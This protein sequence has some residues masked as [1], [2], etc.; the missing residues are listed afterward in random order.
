MRKRAKT[1]GEY[2]M[3][4]KKERR[5][6][7]CAPEGAET[8]YLVAGQELRDPGKT[9]IRAFIFDI[10]GTL[11]D[12]FEAY[13]KAF[14]Q[15]LADLKMGRLDRKILRSY[16]AE[17]LSLRDILQKVLSSPMDDISYGM[18]RQKIM[19]RFREVE[20]GGVKPFPGVKELFEQLTARGFKI[21]VATGR[22]SSPTDEWERFK[23][24]GLDKYID[25]IVTSAEVV[26]R[27]PAPDA[28]TECAKRLNVPVGQCCVIGDTELDIVAAKSAGAVAVAVTTGQD[29]EE[30]LLKAE[31]VI[32]CR[33]LQD[34]LT[35]LA[36][37]P[38]TGE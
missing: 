13:Y 36:M 1:K 37:P 22:T 34:L 29:D 33:N 7:A 35:Q 32:V 4:E 26:H 24:L 20:Q 10:D 23:K 6:K 21:G 12:S 3:E 27:K 16:L 30:R 17:G 18:C 9:E 5:E 25:A 31:P 8:G 19:S 28:V 11:V 15:G 14:N 2:H 38:H